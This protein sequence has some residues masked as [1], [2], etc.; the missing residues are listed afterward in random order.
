MLLADD[1]EE[2]GFW[3][4]FV[5][6]HWHGGVEVFLGH[7]GGREWDHSPDFKRRVFYLQNVVGWA[8]AA[9]ELQRD[10]A[11]RFPVG[12]PFRAILAM[13]DTT[14]ASLTTFGA[15]WEEPGS[16]GFW[17]QPTAVE[18]NVLLHE[19]L[20]RWPDQEGIRTLALRFGARLD[21]AFGGNGERHLER[22]GPDAGKFIPRW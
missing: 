4:S 8:W 10:I 18:R 11:D 20:E 2:G 7:H 5:A 13:A 22:T 16:A 1:T 21:L 14:G 9:F 17:G 3:R 6:V 12:E 19:D 15:G